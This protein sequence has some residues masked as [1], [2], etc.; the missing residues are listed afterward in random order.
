MKIPTNAWVININPKA[1][2]VKL[3]IIVFHAVTR[4]DIRIKYQ[5]IKPLIH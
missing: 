2:G 1:V 4:N 3:M 5:F